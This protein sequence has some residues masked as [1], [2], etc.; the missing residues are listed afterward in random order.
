MGKEQEQKG[1]GQEIDQVPGVDHPPGNTVKMGLGPQGA[2]KPNAVPI[3]KQGANGIKAPI[4]YKTDQYSPQKGQD[5]VL[6][7]GGGKN[8]DRG[9]GGQ[10]EE[11]SKIRPQDHPQIEIAPYNAQFGYGKYVDHCGE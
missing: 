9:I 10:Q 1:K 5:L 2:D 4:E 3:G 6:R 8:P 11:Q 7:E